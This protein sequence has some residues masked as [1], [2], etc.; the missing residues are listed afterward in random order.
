M[1]RMTVPFLWR[2]GKST[3]RTGFPHRCILG[4]ETPLIKCFAA[5][6]L[7]TISKIPLED[8]AADPRQLEVMES[9]MHRRQYLV[10]D[11]Q[12]SSLAHPGEHALHDVADLTQA[13]AVGRPRLR[14]VVFDPPL[15]EP[16]VIAR[17]AVLPVP[18]QG[19]R[20]A[21]RAAAPSTD[22]RAVIHQVHRLQ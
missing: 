3:S 1:S 8:L 7:G 10:T 15:L 19:L 2:S 22:R 14:Q 17:G 20:L 16:S 6:G 18:I 9:P 5:C 12:A 21:P 13:A 11:L 4:T